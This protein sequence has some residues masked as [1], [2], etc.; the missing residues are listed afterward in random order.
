[1]A[2]NV[3]VENMGEDAFEASYNLQLPEGVDYIKIERPRG[4]GSE[5]AVQCSPP[6]PQNNRTLKCDIGNP[7]P[8][9]QTVS[10]EF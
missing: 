10:I 8:Q 4:R 6:T 3:T 2:I 7:L 9:Q 5:I 1:M